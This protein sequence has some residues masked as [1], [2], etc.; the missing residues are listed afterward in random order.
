MD[1]G[2]AL[3]GLAT[4]A[5]LT[6]IAGTAQA[7]RQ[8]TLENTQAQ[9]TMHKMSALSMQ[10]EWREK[11]EAAEDMKAGMAS[12]A[13]GIK[14]GEDIIKG[15][16]AVMAT[17]ASKGQ[18]S[19]VKSMEELIKNTRAG[20]KGQEDAKMAEQAKA[21]DTA[22][23]AAMVYDSDPTPANAAAVVKSAIAAGVPYDQIPP[24]TDQKAFAKFAS[25]L[26][27]K[28]MSVEKAMAFR[29]TN[30]RAQQALDERIRHDK[31]S[32]NIRRDQMRATAEA[33]EASNATRQLAIAMTA[34]ARSRAAESKK[35]KDAAK[36]SGT[37]LDSRQKNT[38]EQVSSQSHEAVRTIRGMAQMTVGATKGGFSNLSDKGVL[39]SLAKVGGN[40]MT[41][42]EQQFMQANA[43]G[44]AKA[45]M[46]TE[47]AGSGRAPTEAQTNEIKKA[48]IPEI[49]DPPLVAAYKISTGAAIVLARLENR[50]TH[51]DPRIEAHMV[52]DEEW[53][54]TLPTP[55]E[56]YAAGKKNPAMA[57]QLSAAQQSSGTL[58]A[59][60]KSMG[61][62]EPEYKPANQ[63]AAAWK[64]GDP[65]PPPPSGFKVRQ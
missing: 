45:V 50:N 11:Q 29:D 52:K 32:E 19:Q 33:R 8:A 63:P 31:E 34:E 22:G 51:P 35:E 53:L 15:A 26:P 10:K 6:T 58:M 7:Q 54:R 61:L 42:T 43:A 49:G 47:A 56:I 14:T 2:A 59:T 1:W 20:I 28:A 44:F 30:A 4:N 5:G 41:T 48:I 23:T 13:G 21:A 65:I 64:Q 36:A 37:S 3:S 46:L 25:T 57:K 27:T 9:A 17:A 55:I 24:S 40:Y 39:D 12:V 16:T 60:I 38:L 62:K 18:F